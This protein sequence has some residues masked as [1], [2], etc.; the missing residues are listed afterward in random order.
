M[1]FVTDLFRP[2]SRGSSAQAGQ[3]SGRDAAALSDPF[4]AHRG[5]IGNYLA[6][7][8]ANGQTPSYFTPGQGMNMGA[9]IQGMAG[10]GINNGQTLTDMATQGLPVGGQGLPVAGQGLPT[11]GQGIPIAGQGMANASLLNPTSADIQ[12]DPVRA[13][14]MRSM[15]NAVQ[16]SAAASG[17]LDSGGTLAALQQNASDITANAG[18]RLYARN[19]N[20][21]GLQNQAQNQAFGQGLSAQGQSFNQGFATQGANFGQGMAA[22][23][24]DYAQRL[25]S[26]GQGFAQTLAALGFGNNAQNQGFAQNLAAGG[27]TNAA[28]GQMNQQGNQYLNFLAGLAGATPQNAAA[29]GG[30]IVQGFNAGTAAQ[31]SQNQSMLGGDG[32]LFRTI[33]NIGSWLFPSDVRLKEDITHVGQTHAGLPIY[34][35]RYK[36]GGPKTMGVMAQDVEKVDP[37]AVTT[38]ASGFKLVNYGKVH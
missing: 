38:H 31:G 3:Q 15:T 36:W 6:S 33:G 1:S 16:N 11:A 9:G 4:S 2:N 20:T 17:T 29:A 22:Q 13:A 28:Q 34:S 10:Q 12:N 21:F 24:Q 35:Y 7:L 37:D 8:F 25:G 5:Q 27:F 32:S 18:D 30:N 23:Q 26:Q 19:A 14:Q